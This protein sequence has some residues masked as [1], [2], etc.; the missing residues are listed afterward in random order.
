MKKHTQLKLAFLMFCFFSATLFAGETIENQI[1][2]KGKPHFS[3][4]NTYVILESE[5]VY[6]R[7]NLLELATET[8]TLINK[9]V[10]SGEIVN[11]KI[12]ASS[13]TFAWPKNDRIFIKNKNSEFVDK[14]FLKEEKGIVNISGKVAFSYNDSYYLFQ[15]GNKIIQLEKNKLD[16]RQIELL[17][18]KNVGDLAELRVNENAIS[19]NW[20][21]EVP[22]IQK[23][24]QSRSI[25]STDEDRPDEI[26]KAENILYI[27][28]KVLYS[29]SEP[30]LVIQSKDFIFYLKRSG[31]VT[32]RPDRL[33]L[34]GSKVIISVPAQYIEFIWQL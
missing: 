18:K 27:N 33:D 11:L 32:D 5:N 25:A 13:I 29:A 12:P 9:A 4:S 21:M 7:V 8:S 14:Y 23:Y 16:S 1:E 26:I 22:S 28:G 34:I 6:Y 17:N 19:Y 24:T 20:E 31:I 3:F 15:I 30:T 10:F 2:V